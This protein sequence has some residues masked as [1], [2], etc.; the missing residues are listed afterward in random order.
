LTNIFPKWTNR[1]P[2][3]IA[4]GAGSG[5]VFVVAFVTYY[6]SPRNTDVGYSPDQPGN[7]SHKLHAGLLGFDCRYCH[8]HV[9]DGPHATVP[10]TET[11]MNCHTQV[12]QKSEWL[13]PVR[14]SFASGNPVPW[15]KVHML[16]DFAYFDHSVHIKAGIGCVS[17]HGRIDQMEIVRQVQP[18]SMSW[19]IECHRAPEKHVRPTAEVTNMDYVHDDAVAEHLIKEKNINPPT[20][21]SACHR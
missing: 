3:L 18:L 2:A 20:H 6:F 19:C 5:L 4:L 12:K 17:C 13:Q 11:C 14:D 1:L 8:Q 15:V 7:Y 16:P 9:E 21:C 10:P